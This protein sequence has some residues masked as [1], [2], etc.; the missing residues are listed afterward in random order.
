MGRWSAAPAWMPTSSPA[1]PSTACADRAAV[2]QFGHRISPELVDLRGIARSVALLRLL[3]R[4]WSER[5]DPRLTLTRWLG[6]PAQHGQRVSCHSASARRHLRVAVHARGTAN[7]LL[8]APT[9]ACR[10][11]GVT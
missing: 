3:Y 4:P 1:S 6:S 9:R 11:S 7:C 2:G 10:D 5:R 8:V